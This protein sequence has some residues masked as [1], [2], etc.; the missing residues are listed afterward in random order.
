MVKRLNLSRA[1]KGDL[2]QNIVLESGDI[3]FVPKKFIA[4]LNYFMTEVLGPVLQGSAAYNSFKN[5]NKNQ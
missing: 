4:N 3:V 5:W 2:S 1:L